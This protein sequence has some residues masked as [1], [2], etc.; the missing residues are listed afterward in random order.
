MLPGNGLRPINGDFKGH[1][2]MDSDGSGK[3]N[4]FFD[5]SCFLDFQE[6]PGSGTLSL[7][8]VVGRGESEVGPFVMEGVYDSGTHILSLSRRYLNESDPLAHKSIGELKLFHVR[9]QQLMTLNLMPAVIRRPTII[10]PFLNPTSGIRA[11]MQ[12]TAVS[13]ENSVR[14]GSGSHIYDT[15]SAGVLGVRKLGPGLLASAGA[16]GAGGAAGGGGRGAAA[17]AYLAPAPTA[18]DSDGLHNSNG[19]S[20]I[21][22]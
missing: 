1:Q 4:K 2:T 18:S 22:V 13:V 21:A 11:S 6:V 9:Q 15:P 12:D 20:P 5:R 19:T 16:G 8:A 17:T 7:Y 3:S 14:V 10:E